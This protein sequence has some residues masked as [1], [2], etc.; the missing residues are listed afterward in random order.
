MAGSDVTEAVVS[1]PI[2]NRKT[3]E[4]A[5]GVVGKKETP[6][7]A[8]GTAHPPQEVHDKQGVAQHKGIVYSSCQLEAHL[9]GVICEG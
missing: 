4:E 8:N 3:G 5:V 1:H 2:D 6:D 9:P 7:E